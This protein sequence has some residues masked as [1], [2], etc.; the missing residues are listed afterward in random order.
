RSIGAGL[1]EIMASRVAVGHTVALG[2]IFG[3]FLSYLSTAQQIF[4]V[5]YDTGA[6]FALYFGMAALT[7]GGASVV[8][9]LLVMRMGMRHLT[10]LALSGL[11]GL[12]LLFL[13]PTY[14]W[15]G[16]PPLAL[17]MVWLMASFFCVGILF[18]NLNAIAMEPLGHI[19]GLGAALIGSLSNFIALPISYFIGHQFNGTVVPLVLGFGT[20]GILALYA[21]NWAGRARTTPSPQTGA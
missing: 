16:T 14:L 5:A 10:R 12:A 6:L 18:G 17:F 2:L 7:I 21:V 13:I 9:S 20:V 19:A 15:D 1:R 8:N 4:Q 3:V 11:S